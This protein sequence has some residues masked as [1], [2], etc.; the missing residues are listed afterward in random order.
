M[1]K[2]SI[3]NI[4]YYTFVISLLLQYVSIFIFKFFYSSG[5]QIKFAYNIAI[6]LYFFAYFFCFVGIIFSFKAKQPKLLLFSNLLL[7]LIF[8]IN[9]FIIFQIVD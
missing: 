6:F 5:V 4:S 7:F 3:K 9:F 8:K 2:D 1:K